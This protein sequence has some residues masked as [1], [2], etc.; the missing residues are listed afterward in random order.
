MSKGGNLRD[1]EENKCNQPQGT[2]KNKTM[3][4][5]IRN[6]YYYNATAG[7]TPADHDVQYDYYVPVMCTEGD[8]IKATARL[9]IEQ[10]KIVAEYLEDPT[11]HYVEGVDSWHSAHE[12]LIDLVQGMAEELVR[13]TP[14]CSD[15]KEYSAV[16]EESFPDGSYITY[17]V[18]IDVEDF[19]QN[20]Y[21]D[22]SDNLRDYVADREALKQ[23][24]NVNA[25]D[26]HKRHL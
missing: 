24:I 14:P 9:E 17:C 11:G 12:Y 13:N 26:L 4:Q 7:V 22:C 18:D 3:E 19:D 10:P 16:I 1:T 21:I 25:E 8:Y 15:V 20:L 23:M 6:T 5:T 2:N